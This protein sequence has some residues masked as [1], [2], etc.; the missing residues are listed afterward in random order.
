MLTAENQI[1]VPVRARR[2]RKSCY[3][4]LPGS[5][6][7]VFLPKLPAAAGVRVGRPVTF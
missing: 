1:P 6:K 7:I 4:T 2:V 5:P 3:I